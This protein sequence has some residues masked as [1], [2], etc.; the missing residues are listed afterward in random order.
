MLKLKKILP[1]LLIIVV[2]FLF[3]VFDIQN[4]NQINQ[5]VVSE[6]LI[7]FELTDESGRSVKLSDLKS[8][9]VVLAFGWTYCTTACPKI[10]AEM[11]KINKNYGEQITS[12]FVALDNGPEI[13]KNLARLRSEFKNQIVFLGDANNN[14]NVV[15]EIY[16]KSVSSRGLINSNSAN[17]HS[18]MMFWIDKKENKTFIYKNKMD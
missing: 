11:L 17:E 16:L 15:Y 8:R 9:Y 1:Y 14:S 2:I 6:K 3:Q 7:D 5:L 4:F 13:R 10:W 18:D 12:V